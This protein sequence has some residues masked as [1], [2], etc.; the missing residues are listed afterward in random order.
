MFFE[1]SRGGKG[2]CVT[3]FSQNIFGTPRYP[4]IFWEKLVAHRPFPPPLQ[5]GPARGTGHAAPQEVQP[6][7]PKPPGFSAPLPT[8]PPGSPSGCL[9]NTLLRAV[10]QLV[11]VRA[12]LHPRPPSSGGRRWRRAP[13]AWLPSA[14]RQ[15]SCC[16]RCWTSSW[17]RWPTQMCTRS[18]V[19]ARDLP[20]LEPAQRGSLHMDAYGNP[21]AGNRANPQLEL[22]LEF[23][24]RSC[25]AVWCS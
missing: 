8:R 19:T 14:R 5:S 17:G 6:V 25:V 11:E 15:R 21:K 13:P 3:S 1:R 4:K 22:S 2:R 7:F 10:F 23:R 18:R 9:T 24:L 16:R 12:G 20:Q